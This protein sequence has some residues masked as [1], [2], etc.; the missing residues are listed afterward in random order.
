[1]KC[2][3]CKGS[4]EYVGARIVE[5]CRNCKGAGT[6]VDTTKALDSVFTYNQPG[7]NPCLDIEWGALAG[8]PRVIDKRDEWVDRSPD[9]TT[10][11]NIGEVVHVYDAGWYE[12]TIMNFN[13][14]H[15]DKQ[16]HYDAKY[17]CGTFNFTHSQLTYN[18]T[19]G[20]WELVRSG[21]PVWH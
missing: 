9:L 18:I 2:P 5:K 10:T 14:N 8:N 19:Q 20:R 1:M 7:D 13:Y 6:L 11:L 16:T 4:G 12:A 21:T 3:D 15:S 17:A